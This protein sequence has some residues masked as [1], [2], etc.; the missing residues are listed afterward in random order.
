M[1]KEEIRSS[2]ATALTEVTAYA[3][4]R[5]DLKDLFNQNPHIG[6]KMLTAFCQTLSNYIFTISFPKRKKNYELDEVDFLYF[7]TCVACIGIVFLS[8]NL[9]FDLCLYL[10]LY[11]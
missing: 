10:L 2:S 4:S 3:V 6:V 11:S 9:L 1:F 7:I 8:H 5:F